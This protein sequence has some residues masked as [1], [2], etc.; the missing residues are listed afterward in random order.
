MCISIYM[1]VCVGVCVCEE[2]L[3]VCE[4]ESDYRRIYLWAIE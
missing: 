2:E 1:C 4:E 3:C